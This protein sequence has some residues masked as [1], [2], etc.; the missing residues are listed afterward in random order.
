VAIEAEQRYLAGWG[1]NADITWVVGHFSAITSQSIWVGLFDNPT[2]PIV[3]SSTVRHIG[4][5]IRNG[6]I[7]ASVADGTTNGAADTLQD[8]GTTFTTPIILRIQWITGTSA[9]FYVNGTFT[10]TLSTNIPTGGSDAPSIVVGIRAT[11]NATRAFDLM[12]YYAWV[13]R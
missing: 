2:P 13:A 1:K 4:F 7:F 11:S 8:I 5:E 6:D 3:G 12:A 9:K 10:N